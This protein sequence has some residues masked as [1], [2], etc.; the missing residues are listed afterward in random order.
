MQHRT[1]ETPFLVAP[2]GELRGERWQLTKDRFVIGRD[3]ECDLVVADRQVSREHVEIRK[4]D[5]GYVIEDLNSKNGTHLNGV[6]LKTP[7]LLQ[8]GDEIQVAFAIKLSFVGSEATLPL[9]LDEG[10]L[11]GARLLRIEIQAHRVWIG[12]EEV[13]PP[14]SP[15][16]FRLLELLHQNFTRVVTR[17]EIAEHVWPGTHG[18]GVSDQAI[19]ALIR[20]LR[21]RLA[22]INP[23]QEFI[24]TVRGHGFR[25]H[26]PLR[27]E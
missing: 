5:A 1:E 11:D 6:R 16:Q 2:T 13:D 8:D 26:N 12:D 20:R 10:T 7:S 9:T 23:D 21:D 15:P 24:V 27:A 25:L 18:V 4:S 19:D 3:P 17:E 22:D 14:L